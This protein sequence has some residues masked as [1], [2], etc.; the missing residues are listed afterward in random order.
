MQYTHADLKKIHKI[1]NKNQKIDFKTRVDLF[2][3][4]SK[5]AAIFGKN[6]RGPKESEE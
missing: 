5:F 4:I 3:E 6:K 1:A 2:T